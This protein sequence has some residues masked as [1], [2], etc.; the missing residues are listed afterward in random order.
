VKTLEKA[1]VQLDKIKPTEGTLVPWSQEDINKYFHGVKR[2]SS[3]SHTLRHSQESQIDLLG[4]N[5]RAVANR[6][7][8]L[9]WKPRYTAEDC[10]PTIL[11][12]AEYTLAHI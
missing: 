4:A 12:E 10:H 11:P 2:L 5:C 3:S 6:A 9:G 1:L 8:A 7:R